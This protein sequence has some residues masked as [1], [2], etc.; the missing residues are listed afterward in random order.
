M[1]II[2]FENI[3]AHSRVVTRYMTSRIKGLKMAGIRD[4]SPGIWNHSAR[5][6]D[7]QYF[8]WNEDWNEGIRGQIFAGSGIKILIIFGIGGQNFG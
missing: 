8:P 7:Q 3:E 5:D 6:R 4:H 1:P 2:K